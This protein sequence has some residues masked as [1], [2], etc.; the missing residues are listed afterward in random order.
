MAKITTKGIMLVDDPEKT[1]K[2]LCKVKEGQITLD[3]YADEYQKILGRRKPLH[4]KTKHTHF[5][6]LKIFDLI[7][8]IGRNKYVATQPTH[9]LCSCFDKENENYKNIV[10]TAIFNSEKKEFFE[11]F[12]KKFNSQKKTQKDFL[13]E[14]T[15]PQIKTLCSWCVYI[16]LVETDGTWYWKIKSKKR[17]SSFK[18]F[19]KSFLDNFKRMNRTEIFTVRKYYLDINELRNTVCADMKITRE[20]FDEFLIKLVESRKIKIRLH[21]A[22]PVY[23][24]HE[25]EWK[26]FHYK[27]KVY[28]FLSIE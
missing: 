21:G 28:H 20:D 13:D 25:L 19:V 14:Y 10:Y 11:G 2:A 6:L 1:L 7:K 15:A 18:K 8:P 4:K 27:R 5:Y 22:P 23:S 3:R 12:L 26:S 17:R 16:G 24:K 9:D